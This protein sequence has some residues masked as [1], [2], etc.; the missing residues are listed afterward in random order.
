MKKCLKCK[1]K[2]SVN[3]F[4][5]HAKMLDGHL[6]I[7]KTCTKNRIAKYRLENKEKINEYDRNR[8]NKKQRLENDK[9]RRRFRPDDFDLNRTRRFRTKYPLKTKAHRITSY[10]ISKGKLIKMPCEICGS[11][12]VQAH[13]ENYEKPLDVMWLCVDH[14]AEL[15]RKKRD[16]ERVNK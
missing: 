16:A 12:D 3:S 14:H 1:T 11:K 4:Y 2:Q 10:A 15:H 9:I 8:P 5:R 6:N 13:H 7:C